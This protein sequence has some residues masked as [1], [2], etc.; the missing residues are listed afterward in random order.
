MTRNRNWLVDLNPCVKNNVKFA[1]NGIIVAGSIDKVLIKRKDGKST[2][3]ND[4][5][6]VPTMRKMYSAWDNCW[7][8]ATQ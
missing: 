6:Y 4:V 5:L 7:K 1:D 3:M 2:F 8:R